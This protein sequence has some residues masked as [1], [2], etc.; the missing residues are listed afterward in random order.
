VNS[1]LK[2]ALQIVGAVASLISIY[3]AG[4]RRGWI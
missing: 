4:H 3:E 2:Q 1:E